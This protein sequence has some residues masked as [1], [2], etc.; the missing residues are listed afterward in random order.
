ME[1]AAEEKIAQ[2]QESRRSGRVSYKTSK[3]EIRVIGD[4]TEKDQQ[5]SL[6]Y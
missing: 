4:S 6:P 3:N 1:L 5:E 2:A